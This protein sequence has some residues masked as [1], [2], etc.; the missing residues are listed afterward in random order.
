MSRARWAVPAF[1]LGCL[2]L[3]HC[4]AEGES[5]RAFP[6]GATS[7]VCVRVEELAIFEK[8]WSFEGACVGARCAV[9]PVTG[10]VSVGESFHPSDQAL[11]LGGGGVARLPFRSP[12]TPD[13]AR[14]SLNARCEEGAT[15]WLDGDGTSTTVEAVRLAGAGP[16]RRVDRTLRNAL[17]R[18]DS[19]RE[20]QQGET[21]FAPQ[22]R[23][24]GS[25]ACAVDRVRLTLT[26]MVCTAHVTQTEYC[27]EWSRTAPDAS[28]RWDDVSAAKDAPDDVR[29]DAL[30]DAGRPDADAA[31][32]LDAPKAEDAAD[33]VA[34]ADAAGDAGDAD[35]D[36]VVDATDAAGDADAA[37]VADAGARE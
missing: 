19:I 18:Y 24:E 2:A 4:L 7:V 11:R 3:E 10:D 29:E 12:G 35:A 32:A 37:D 34:T 22:L 33:D 17:N 30:V 14:L 6:C 25:G 28:A 21:Q 27:Y 23:V 9:E 36:D 26:A 20:A 8:S 1:A 15:L 16:W 13:G 5:L 31:T